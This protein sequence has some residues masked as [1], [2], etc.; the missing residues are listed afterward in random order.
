V[1]VVVQVARKVPIGHAIGVEAA[2]GLEVVAEATGMVAAVEA[3]GMVAAE[4]EVVAAGH[5]RCNRPRVCHR[6]HTRIQRHN[7]CTE[8]SLYRRMC[9]KKVFPR[10][11]SRRSLM[12]AGACSRAAC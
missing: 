1:I 11:T 2:M 7:R 3:T 10:R 12:L 4:A 5:R 6:S 9:R 8:N